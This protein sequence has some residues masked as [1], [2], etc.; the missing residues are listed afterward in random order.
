MAINEGDP[1]FG[2][3]AQVQLLFDIAHSRLRRPGDPCG[4]IEHRVATMP[5]AVVPSRALSALFNVPTLAAY[6]DGADYMYLANDDLVLE[7]TGW[8]S[9]FVTALESN[10]LVSNLG[11]AGAADT[12]DTVTPQIE[13][14]F[15]HRT[16]VELFEWCGANPWVFRNWWE[17]NWVT[18]VYLP[19]SSVFYMQDVTVRNYGGLVEASG[20]GSRGATDPRY[21]LSGGRR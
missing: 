14:P 1:V 5:N 10:P 6:R 12:S 16:H 8:T 4:R 11:V 3:A 9:S 13:F 20:K 7:S 19:F 21:K 17:D 2:D 15:F 18:D